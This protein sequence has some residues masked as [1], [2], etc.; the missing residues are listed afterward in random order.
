MKKPL[1]ILYYR[2][3]WLMVRQPRHEG[4]QRCAWHFHSVALKCLVGG[5]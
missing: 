2:R 1:A 4:V 3:V 5:S